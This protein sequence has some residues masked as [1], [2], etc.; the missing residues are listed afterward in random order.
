MKK[1]RREFLAALNRRLAV[2]NCATTGVR[3][4]DRELVSPIIVGDHVQDTWTFQYG[5][6]TALRNDFATIP[7]Q[8]RIHIT[9]LR[10]V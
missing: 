7:N 1:C 3:S 9:Q 8:G 5:K 6:V 4:V 2:V 10:K